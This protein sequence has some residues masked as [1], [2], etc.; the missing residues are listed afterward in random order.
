MTDWTKLTDPI[1]KTDYDQNADLTTIIKSG[2]AKKQRVLK[3]LENNIGWK[4][5]DIVKKFD[6][7]CDVKKDYGNGL[8]LM[9]FFTD[10]S[11]LVETFTLTMPY[12]EVLETLNKKE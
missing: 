7:D 9:S 12:K 3:F 11:M 6:L 8:V 1:V 2:V 5:T 10:E 4:I